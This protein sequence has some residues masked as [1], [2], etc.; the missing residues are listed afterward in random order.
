MND[1][2]RVVL[3]GDSLGMPTGKDEITYE[4]TYPYI[5]MKRLKE[6]E[7]ISKH[8]R[9]NDTSKQLAHQAIFDD[10]EMINPDYMAIHLGIVDCAPRLFSRFQNA[11]IGMLP[12]V[13]S[14]Y[15]IKITSNYRYLLTKIFPKVYVSKDQY[16]MNLEK[17]IELSRELNIIPIFIEILQT[18]K[19]NKEK[20]F[21][22]EKNINDYN[23]ILY[24]IIDRNNIH[25]IK[26]DNSKNYLLNDGIHITKEANI[27]IATKIIKY[28]K[29]KKC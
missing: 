17:F 13:I 14:K 8:K 7:V 1:T 25:L 24:E 20:S 11:V 3:L 9:T 12:N 15:I 26:Y 23:N 4:D 19:L 29:E 16:K 2:S 5:L 6:Y 21:S 10:I 18:S 28:I 27:Y 22:F